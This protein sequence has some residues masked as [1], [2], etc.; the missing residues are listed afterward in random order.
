MECFDKKDDLLMELNAG[1]KV[2]RDKINC[3]SMLRVEM[4][5][6]YDMLTL[7]EL[8]KLSIAKYLV[9][10]VSGPYEDSKL[11]KLESLDSNCNTILGLCS[12]T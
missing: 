7:I 11:D 5:I 6:L 1:K 4:V 12:K 3:L 9:D 10:S 2:I 8:E